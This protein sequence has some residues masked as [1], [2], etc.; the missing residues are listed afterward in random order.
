MQSNIHNHLRRNLV[1]SDISQFN[2]SGWFTIILYDVFV[3]G[4]IS[5]PSR[6]VSAAT[7][8]SNEDL[9]ERDGT[10]APFEQSE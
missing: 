3:S 6:P 8:S 9:E 10:M 5:K 7:L 1:T 2:T 4:D